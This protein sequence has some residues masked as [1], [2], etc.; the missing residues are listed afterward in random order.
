MRIAIFGSSGFIGSYLV[1]F[2]KNEGHEVLPFSRK[3]NA[4][5]FWDPEKKIV[6]KTV[7][8]GVEVIINLSGDNIF[9][10]W[11][12]EKKEKIKNSRL[13]S[14]QFLVETIQTLKNPPKLYM[15][16]SAI[17]YYGDRGQEKLNENSLPGNGFLA[18]L[19][20]E[21][22][23]KANQ[24]KIRVAMLRF[25]VVIGKGGALS[26]MKPAFKMGLGG[27]LGDGS[28]IVS[29][30]EI[31]DAA[32]AISFIIN[33]ESLQGP[34]NLVSPQPVTNWE[35]T[36]TLGKLLERPTILAMPSFMLKIIFGEGSEAYLSSAYVVC[37][38]LKKEGFEFKYPLIEEALRKNL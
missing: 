30:I 22:E 24:L 9:G 2:L 4:K 38:K 11:G 12:E 6:D 10:R 18:D 17:G 14:T 1:S 34:I 23:K 35:M 25:G 32:R 33:H 5:Y 37:E 19:C 7:L 3:E 8:E 36:K 26:K 31:E 21:L 13:D 27:T 28:Q 29:W 15:G 20:V 16:A